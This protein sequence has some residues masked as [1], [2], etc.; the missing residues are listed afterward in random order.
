LKIV[1]PVTHKD[2]E[3][4]LRLAAQIALLRNV[5]DYEVLIVANHKGRNYAEGVAEIIKPFFGATNIFEVANQCEVNR[6]EAANH[7]FRSAVNFLDQSGN[8][9]PWYWFEA[10]N[11]L[12]DPLWLPKIAAGYRRAEDDGKFFMGHVKPTPSMAQDGTVTYPNPTDTFMVGTSVYPPQITRFTRLWQTAR[13]TPWDT[14]IRWEIK[15]YVQDSPLFAHNWN[16]LNYRV[17]AG[18]LVCDKGSE[19]SLST[20]EPECN[21]AAVVFHGCKDGSLVDLV[22]S[23]VEHS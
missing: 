6:T 21:K 16:T 12:L 11:T 20:T 15:R 5:Q 3:I 7:M 13:V 23:A 14:Y 10:D 19:K 18:K 17:E 1:F 22:A 2:G 8:E 4:A 9:S